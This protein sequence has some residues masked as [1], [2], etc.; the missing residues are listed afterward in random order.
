MT[1]STFPERK[2]Y[3]APLP[4]PNPQRVR[5]FLH[6][7]RINIPEV[8]VSIIAGEHKT[9]GH[10]NPAQQLPFLE[11]EDGTVIAETMSICRF[12]EEE[13]PQR[14]PVLFGRTPLQKGLIDQWIRRVEFILMTPIAMFWVH[15]HPLTKRL[16]RTKYPEFGEDCRTQALKAMQWFNKQMTKDYLAGEEFTAADIALTSSIDFAEFIGVVVP[17]D[18]TNLLKWRERVK[19]RPSANL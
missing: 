10:K 3:G 15:A 17:E 8:T 2:W 13:D 1:S 4:A 6:E 11:L 18:C 14:E 19:A 12:L 16:P 5:M 7:K 9:L